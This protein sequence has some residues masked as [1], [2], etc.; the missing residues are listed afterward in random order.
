M[1]ATINPGLTLCTEAGQPTEARIIERVKNAIENG[2]KCIYNC[3]IEGDTT[4]YDVPK[5]IDVAD[6]FNPIPDGEVF[7]GWS[8]F[9]KMQMLDM[10]NSVNLA[11]APGKLR[12]LFDV[13][14]RDYIYGEGMHEIFFARGCHSVAIRVDCT[15]GNWYGYLISKTQAA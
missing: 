4:A 2:G 14:T 13:P 6:A 3:H 12:E 7:A 11:L 9:T 8:G 5:L 1:E 10:D 15:N